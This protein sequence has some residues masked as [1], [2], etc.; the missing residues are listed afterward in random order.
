MDKYMMIFRNTPTSE[1][2]YQSMS[3]EDMQASLD[4]WGAWIGGIAAQGKLI[5]SD[6]LEQQGKI[7]TGSKKAI[8]DGPY[9]ES[10]ELVS[11]YL[12]M[13]AENEAEAVEAAKGCPIFDMEGSVEVRKLMVFN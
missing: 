8:T 9:V 3:P 1:E 7:L 12:L 10:K 13:Q 4:Q 2:A 5:G 11:G 6:A